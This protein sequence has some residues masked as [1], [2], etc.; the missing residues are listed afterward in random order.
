M[1]NSEDE[2]SE[3]S[4]VEATEEELESEEIEDGDIITYV[5]SFEYVVN[6]VPADTIL[7]P[8]ILQGRVSG[9]LTSPKTIGEQ[10]ILLDNYI[11]YARLQGIALRIGRE[12]IPIARAMPL[13]L[14]LSAEQLPKLEKIYSKRLMPPIMAEY[15]GTWANAWYNVQDGNHRCYIKYFKFGEEE[16]E[17]FVI[18]L[19]VPPYKTSVGRLFGELAQEDFILT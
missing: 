12:I 8:D 18:Y 15:M 16:I 11:R 17:A 5:R 1:E 9:G 2:E 14:E 10:R 6:K 4:E 19:G 13:H 3:E 7:P